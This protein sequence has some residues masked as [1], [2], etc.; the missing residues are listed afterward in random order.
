MV[1]LLLAGAL[2]WWAEKERSTALHRSAMNS[3][4]GSVLRVRL[5]LLQMSD[6]LP[7]LLSDPKNNAERRHLADAE[8]DLA[9]S[10]QNLRQHGSTPTPI[11][12]PCLNNI[13]VYAAA[14]R[15]KF[16]ELQHGDPAA[17]RAE[18]DRVFPSLQQERDRLL[19]DLGQQVLATVRHDSDVASYKSTAR[20]HRRLFII[21][22]AQHLGRRLPVH[23]RRPPP[24]RTRRNPPHPPFPQPRNS[25]TPPWRSP[26]SSPT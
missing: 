6:A 16:N 18:Y 21:L 11:C 4:S 12:S 25:R 17:A 8:R 14:L 1:L 9:A 24:L 26:S 15:K 20:R 13:E 23:R 2:A 22:V 10:I 7:S 3:L 19:L 5:S